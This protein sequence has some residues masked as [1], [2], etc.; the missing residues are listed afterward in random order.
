MTTPVNP[1]STLQFLFDDESRSWRLY[2]CIEKRELEAIGNPVH[3]VPSTVASPWAPLCVHQSTRTVR[4]T[5]SFA[6]RRCFCDFG[7]SPSEERFPIGSIQNHSLV[8]MQ[9]RRSGAE[10]FFCQFF[11]HALAVQRCD[12]SVLN[13]IELMLVRQVGVTGLG[14]LIAV[15]IR[16]CSQQMV[17]GR[18]REMLSRHAMVVAGGFILFIKMVDWKLRQCLGEGLQVGLTGHKVLSRKRLQ[19][20]LAATSA[21]P[22]SMKP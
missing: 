22:G 6:L 21:S 4:R 18:R 10:V 19:R 5:A 12:F 9:Q 11:F 17:P 20:R 13:P 2:S 7:S 16:C 3:F 14:L 1:I 15:V 8:W